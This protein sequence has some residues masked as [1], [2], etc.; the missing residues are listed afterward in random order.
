MKNITIT[1]AIG[2]G[3]I[4][5]LKATLDQVKCQYNEIKINP[6]NGLIKW[7]NRDDNYRDFVK[8]LTNLLFNEM[9]YK[10]VDQG[11]EFK[12]MSEVYSDHQLIVQKPN[13]SQLC[14]GEPLQIEP[15][16]VMTTKV[17]YLFRN[18]LKDQELWPILNSLPYKIVVLG[19]RE[20]EMNNEYLNDNR[21]GPTVYSIYSEIINNLGDKIIDKTIPALGIIAPNLKQLQ[22]DAL[23]MSGSKA[24]IS[25]GI[26]GNFT[27][28]MAVAK[29]LIGYKPG[30]EFYTDIIFQ[31]NE[32][33]GNSF[34]TK[35]WQVFLKKL[36]EI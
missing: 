33:V 31:H 19:E 12:S 14:N 26:G 5:Y 15:Y 8:D 3:D 7:A 2:L 13:I 34:V 29:K 30:N 20:V 17:R 24:V 10:I 11:P 32:Q 28:G 25:F 22:Q 4:L 1:T 9:P 21:N 35:D 27:T 36:S 23:I 16:I 6:A 18:E